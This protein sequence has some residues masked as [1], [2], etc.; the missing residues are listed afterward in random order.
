MLV[1]SEF[2]EV[3]FTRLPPSAGHF[4]FS[5]VAL[6]LSN[7]SISPVKSTTSA[8]SSLLSYLAFLTL[9]IYPVV[10]RS[11]LLPGDL[12]S[13]HIRPIDGVVYWVFES[14]SKVNLVPFVDF[15]LLDC[16]LSCLFILL[17]LCIFVVSFF[18]CLAPRYLASRRGFCVS[19]AFI[20]A[21]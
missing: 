15:R 12:S 14:Y 7:Q 21:I 10:S 11:C 17:H 20:T 2:R 6:T 9:S 13:P 5:G 16:S 3:K 4:S 1:D 8:S 19:P 18:A